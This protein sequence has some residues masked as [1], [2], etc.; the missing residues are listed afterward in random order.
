MPRRLLLAILLLIAAPLVLL[1]WSSVR[2][3]R[4]E[5]L[6]AKQR[7]TQL[8]EQRLLES[9][10]ALRA[11]IDRYERDLST[12][13]A[14][15]SG[16]KLLDAL[17]DLER[18]DPIVRSTLLLQASGAVV[19]P[20]EPLSDELSQRNRYAALLS[21]AASRPAISQAGDS[22]LT[23]SAPVLRPLW[24]PWFMDQ[25]LQLVLW[26]PKENDVVVGILLERSRWIADLIAVSPQSRS[27]SSSDYPRRTSTPTKETTG[28]SELVDEQQRTI[29]RW[30]DSPPTDLPR[31]AQV[32]VAAPLSNWKLCYH[33]DL[34]TLS[35]N[36]S[37]TTI[38]LPLIATLVVLASLGA[39]VLTSTQRQMRLA[40]DQV[41]FA[42][43]VSHELRTP[44]TNIRLYADLAKSDIESLDDSAVK[45]KIRPRLDVIAQESE[46]LGGLV[47]GVLEFIRGDSSAAVLHPRNV[48]LGEAIDQIIEP[49][50][51]GFA[52]AGIVCERQD[53][54]SGLVCIDPNILRIVLVNLLGNVE[55]YAAQGQYVRVESGVNDAQAIV[56]VCDRG[57]G[58]AAKHRRHVFEA[59]ARLD[60]STSAPSG[61]GIGLA[62]ALA[63]AKRHGGDLVIKPSSPP[64]VC[65][66][67]TLPIKPLAKRDS[68]CR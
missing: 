4:N 18:T 21:L 40:R 47:S 1:G 19:H 32:V 24:Q 56:R 36:A 38:W 10:P 5:N 9:E 25:G 48:D 8:L 27:D 46:R 63:A 2:G 64:G 30:G 7:L 58:I 52:A 51:P 53:N 6:I 60:N 61:T 67:L 50:L 12:R 54:H 37:A 65:F 35:P 34:A 15:L 28:Y 13:L 43:Q 26:M 42:G 23:K 22:T 57:P 62:I 20:A 31:L 29:Y 11:V 41:S 44:L 17:R 14:V 49:F 45:Q 33:G 55:K 39:Y 59:F 3:L 68:P 66:E 16:P